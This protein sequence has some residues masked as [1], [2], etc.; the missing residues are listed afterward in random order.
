MRSIGDFSLISFLQLSSF[1]FFFHNVLQTFLYYP[2]EVN[3]KYK[4]FEVLFL[5][6]I[7]F[8]NC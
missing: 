7:T 2:V 4:Y 5:L 8:H 6:L 3:T 1:T